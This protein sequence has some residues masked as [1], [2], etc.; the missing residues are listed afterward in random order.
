MVD[1]LATRAEEGRLKSRINT[2]EDRKDPE[3]TIQVL[4]SVFLMHYQNR[5][6][7]LPRMPLHLP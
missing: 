4:T 2:Q 7:T 5:Y 3:E 6:E 1:A